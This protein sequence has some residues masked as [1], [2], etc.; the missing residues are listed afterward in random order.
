MQTY[1]QTHEIRLHKPLFWSTNL[2][3]NI[4]NYECLKEWHSPAN[5]FY[6]RQLLKFMQCIFIYHLEWGEK[7]LPLSCWS[8][9][10]KRQ[11][12]A[13]WN[14]QISLKT[15]FVHGLPIIFC[16]ITLTAC[17]FSSI[18]GMPNNQ[19]RSIPLSFFVQRS[20]YWLWRRNVFCHSKY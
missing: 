12:N 2:T 13:C 15:F 11:K 10:V 4:I 7:L 19:S 20:K 16:Y 9:L 3:I 5:K 8:T 14:Y 6:T 17:K 1:D 18:K